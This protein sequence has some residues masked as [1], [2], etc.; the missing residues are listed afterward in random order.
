M[1]RRFVHR[2]DFDAFK[3]EA[4][5]KIIKLAMN[6]KNTTEKLDWLI[7]E[8]IEFK[9]FML[10]HADW[11]VN[12]ILGLQ[13]EQ[14]FTNLTLRRLEEAVSEIP[15]L[16]S[17]VSVLKTDVSELK[18]DVGVL[19]T[20]VAVLKTDV[21]VLKTDVAVLKDTVNEILAKVNEIAK[22]LP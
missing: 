17:D 13:Q 15:G 3:G 8:F 11:T 5:G 20:D 19:K 18:T 7:K 12:A 14:A 1:I 2:R 6:A 21:A 22:K 10:T 9:S 4:E 16:K